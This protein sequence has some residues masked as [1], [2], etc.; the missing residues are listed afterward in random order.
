M[1]L[2]SKFGCDLPCPIRT[3]RPSPQRRR[4]SPRCKSSVNASVNGHAWRDVASTPELDAGAIVRVLNRH[5]VRYVVIGG[6]A[7]Q[8]HEL[9]VPATIDIDVTPARDRKNLERLAGAFDEL[10]AGLYSAE[11]TGT[12]FPRTPVEYWAQYDTLHLMT[13]FGP[14]DIV[15]VPDGAPTGFA[16]LSKQAQRIR[17]NGEPVLVL[18]VRAWET[19]KQAAGRAKDLAHLDAYYENQPDRPARDRRRRPS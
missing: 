14:I 9:P 12:W 2:A 11:K 13:M 6:M 18:T 8:L 19:L 16:E 1:L 15:F 5:G 17:L 7:A 10:E 4:Y 3:D